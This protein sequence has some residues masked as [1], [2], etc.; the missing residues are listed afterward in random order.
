MANLSSFLI[1]RLR[2]DL[3]IPPVNTVVAGRRE[4]VMNSF[5]I[6]T[7]SVSEEGQQGGSAGGKDKAVVTN[8]GISQ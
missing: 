7:P 1:S 5:I 3:H 4:D 6:Q 8:E 2:S